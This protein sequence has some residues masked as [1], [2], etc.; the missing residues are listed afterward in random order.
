[1]N[2]IEGFETTSIH[3]WQSLKIQQ[4]I[5]EGS[6]SAKAWIFG[7]SGGFLNACEEKQIIV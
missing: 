4:G 2:L 7:S 3:S 5:V 1:L 6:E